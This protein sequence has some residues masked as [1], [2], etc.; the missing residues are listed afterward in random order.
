M[1]L[2]YHEKRL[3]ERPFI[4]GLYSSSCDE[5]KLGDQF[6]REIAG[7]SGIITRIPDHVVK[8]MIVV[9]ILGYRIFACESLNFGFGDPRLSTPY[10]L[11]AFC[12][13]SHDAQK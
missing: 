12:L 1:R 3:L 8:I 9:D 6:D 10:A 2:L 4:F 13:R 11:P 7:R 5:N